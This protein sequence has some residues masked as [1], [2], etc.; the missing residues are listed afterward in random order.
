[1][2]VVDYDASGSLVIPG[3]DGADAVVYNPGDIAW[4][5][6]STALVMIMTPGVALFYSGLLRRKNALS[7]L[8]LGM[9]VFSVASFQWFFWG[10]SLT[11]GAGG[12]KFIGTLENFGLMGVLEAE[13]AGSTK[14]PAIVYAIYQSQFAA[15]TPMIMLGATAER[16]R[17]GPALVF[18]FIWATI[19]YDPV[20]CWT[21]AP[22]GWS[23]IMGTLD[24]AGGGPVHIT[25]GVG[26]LSY[27]IWLG[28]RKGYG[29][30]SLAY[31]PQNTTYV[32]LGTV[33]LWFGWF[34]FNGGSAL[35]SNM[36]AAQAIFVTN[37]AAAVGGLTWMLLDYR[38]E[39]KWSAVG[40][41]SGA[42]SGLVCITPGSGY[43]GTPASLAFGIIGA[44][45]CNYATKLKG[46]FRYDDALDIFATHG[47]GGMVG[48]VLTALFADS[49]V[50][51]FDGFTEIPGGW[52]NKNWVQL[53]Y[54]VA[55]TVA[56]SAYAFCVTM[57]LL[58]IL[59]YVPGLSLRVSS[60]AELIGIDEAECGELAYDYVSIRRET[61]YTHHTMKS[62]GGSPAASVH[63][64]TNGAVGS[65]EPAP[66]S[67]AATVADGEHHV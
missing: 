53:G 48:N 31:K 18:T 62:S 29:T 15:L 2:V 41:C 24:F 50:A 66:N 42:I 43:V 33:L 28:K 36:R 40:F 4:I 1:M 11:F 34:G 39:R 63:E 51:G 23:F 9:G 10:Y 35:A 22:N 30:A 21:W 13:S 44:A 38:L 7:L 19:V 5:L 61:D 65:A 58:V 47:I 49:R 67:R 52:I 26:A 20:A 55:D 16:G 3:V 25:S 27:S 64:K 56:I 37:V 45:A 8:S 54:Q 17:I 12:S 59:D 46:I 14:L 6:T 32:I 60:E 57:I